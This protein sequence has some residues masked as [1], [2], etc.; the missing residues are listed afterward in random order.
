MLMCCE[1]ESAVQVG[2]RAVRVEDP[3]TR[4]VQGVGGKSFLEHP[5]WRWRK[6][7]YVIQ[8]ADFICDFFS[9]LMEST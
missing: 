3:S 2:S 4:D 8:G 6:A 5:R 7:V 9:F 1:M